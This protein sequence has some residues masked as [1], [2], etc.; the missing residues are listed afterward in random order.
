M[1]ISILLPDLRGGGAERVFVNLANELVV[2][3]YHID[4]VL[5]NTVG[6][7]LCDL[8][9]E[10]NVVD[11][12]ANRIRNAISPLAKYLGAESPD[13]LIAAMWPLTVVSYISAKLACF[14]G[15]VIFS[16]HSTLSI[17]LRRKG[18]VSRIALSWSIRYLYRYADAIHVVSSGVRADL[19]ELGLP[20][21]LSP[22]VIYNPVYTPR[23]VQTRSTELKLPVV[24]NVGALK[25]AKNQELLIRSFSRVIKQVPAELIIYGEG[26]MRG[27]LEQ[28]IS[29]LG[30][31]D[32]VRMPGF[33]GN[34]SEGYATAN[35]FVL[36]SDWEGFGNVIV[37]AMAHGVPVVSTNCKSG[38]SEILNNGEYGVLVPVNDEKLLAEAIVKE[39]KERKFDS[40]LLIRRASDFSVD[41]ICSQ[42]VDLFQKLVS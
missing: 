20:A 3:G 7:L 23:K 9:S 35:L 25:E 5:L 40:S 34:I 17:A 22:K 12:C 14:K 41:K 16:E 28:V 13:I 2:R 37:E 38:P 27:R 30:L 21:R 4:F 39:L 1:R 24:L 32:Y 29:E 18:F 31:Q 10:I 11:L 6:E 36:S 26:E 42:F 15:K 19:F 8:D 33:L